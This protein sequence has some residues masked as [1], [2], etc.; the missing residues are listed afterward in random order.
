MYLADI[1][2]EV[3]SLR[4]YGVKLLTDL[5]RIPAVN[6]EYGGEGEYD[7]AEYLLNV[8]KDWGFDEIKTIYASDPRAKKSVR[9]NILAFIK[10]SSEDKLWILT[11]LD[12]VPPGD[13][14]AWTVTKPFEPVVKDDKV[15][16]R[17]SED[18]GQAMVSSLL[19]AKILLEKDVKPHRTIVLAFVSDEEAGSKYG[20]D[21]IIRNFRELFSLRD[22][23]LVPD[24]GQ[25]DGGFIEVAE[26]SILWI[27]FKI[28][29]LQT[30]AST[31]HKGL[32]SHRI[33]AEY[34]IEIDKLL[35]EKYNVVNK[36]FEPPTTTCEPTSVSNPSQSPNIIPGEHEFVLDCRILPEYK[37]ENIIEDFKDLFNRIRNK[38]VKKLDDKI[39]PIL[40]TEILMREEA[41]EPTPVDSIIVKTLAEALE[42]LRGIKP[43]IGGIGGGTVASLFRKI[44]I[45]TAVWSTIDET[46]HMPN[47]YSR[48]KNMIE[49][50]KIML[51]LMLNLRKNNIFS[52]IK[53]LS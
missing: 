37:I 15:Y 46:A 11:H 22:V 31:P 23:A 2:K 5:I 52:E 24:A 14:S 18:N 51:Y 7:K 8:I 21:H 17:G 53:N 32:N 6:P 42:K 50:A 41:A 44:G 47:E 20:L 38:H 35:H 13:L 25:S 3:E 43:R 39:Y 48:I 16:G 30:H 9:P 12:V 19:A 1:Y 34:I 4:D 49:D 36:L 33:A 40:Y 45:H 29:G 10:G 26:K 28:K 27:K